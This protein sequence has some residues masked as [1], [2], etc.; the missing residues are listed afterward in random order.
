MDTNS[1]GGQGSSAGLVTREQSALW[2][3]QGGL[4]PWWWVEVLP[5]RGRWKH[6]W[7]GQ[8]WLNWTFL[9]ARSWS[10]A[11]ERQLGGGISVSL[12]SV[13]QGGRP[14]EDLRHC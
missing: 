12:S 7:E 6:C 9:T 14:A 10:Q 1:P 8:G 2:E 13:D 3:G 5:L 11:A 4:G